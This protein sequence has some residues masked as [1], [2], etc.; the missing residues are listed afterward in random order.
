VLRSQRDIHRALDAAENADFA[1]LGIGNLEAGNSGF[2][3]GGFVTG[4]D[5]KVMADAGAVGDIVGRVFE[6]DGTLQDGIY[7]ERV[8][9]IRAEAFP[10]IPARLA[11]AQGLEKVQAIRGALHTG[12]INILCTDDRTAGAVLAMERQYAN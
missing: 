8:I 6:A 3:K 2:V 11:V 7:G 10:Q 1:L 5:L 12:I 9:G 4:E